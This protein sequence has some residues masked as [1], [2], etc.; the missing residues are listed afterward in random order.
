MQIISVT[1]HCNALFSATKVQS[2]PGVGKCCAP[3]V[4]LVCRTFASDDCMTTPVIWNNCN[5]KYN[6][7]QASN[8]CFLPFLDSNKG[9]F[10]LGVD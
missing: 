2:G 7:T 6:F 9:W 3:N 8:I 5:P 4:Y 1:V 10:P